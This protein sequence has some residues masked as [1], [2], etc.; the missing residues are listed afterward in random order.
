MTASHSFTPTR[1]VAALLLLSI[2][3][4]SGASAQQM[5]IVERVVAVVNDEAI[6][7]S[8][9]R[10]RMLPFLP[11]LSRA[12][13][14]AERMAALEQLQT[15]LLDHLVDEELIR[16][17]ARR[18]QVRVSSGDVD[19][20]IANVRAQ[21]ELSEEEFWNA[22]RAQGFTESQYRNDLKAQL[23]RLKVI[24]ERVRGRVNISEEDVR[25]IYEQRVR[26]AN[27]TLRFR[28]SHVFLELP[29][30]PSATDV[31]TTLND[32]RRIRA[33]LDA[34]RFGGAIDTHGGGEL[35]WLSQG[36]L[37][38]ELENVLLGLEPGEVS[39]PVRGPSGVHIFLVHE[40]EEGESAIPEFDQVREQLYRQMLDQAMERQER[41][42]L[43]ELRR[44]A[45]V[46]KRI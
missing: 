15:Q 13:S 37:P 34:A 44:D 27:S 23:L 7:A 8:E 4:P 33:G 20:A 5:E 11:Q 30:D 18:M 46:V 40:R 6:F 22:V 3:A 36:D 39:Q 1:L 29:G 24:N 42:F 2:A 14:E 41:I 25:R 16:Q 26:E 45:I 43:R 19:R 38:E 10:R 32:A 17:A 21:N 28:A 9:L 12:P 31:A 35:G